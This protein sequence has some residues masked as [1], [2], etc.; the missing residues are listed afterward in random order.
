[1]G[2]KTL[3][4]VLVPVADR[5]EKEVQAGSDARTTLEALSTTAREAAEAT[6]DMIAKRGRAS[7][8]GERSRGSVDA[9]AMALAVIVEQVN[10]SWQREALR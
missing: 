4:D 8:T 1:V 5:L 3:L 9:G 10:Q 2:D 6:T 7:Y